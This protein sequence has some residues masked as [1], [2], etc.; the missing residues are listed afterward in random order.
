MTGLREALE[1]RQ[2]GIYFATVLAAAALG[3]AVP[4]TAALEAAINPALALMLFATFLQVPLADLGRALA[5]VRF[6]AALLAAN[7]LVAPLLVLALVQTLP[8][9]PMLR[10]GVL[11]VLL[12]PCIDYVVTFAHIGRADARL[13]LAATPVLL[14]AQMLLLPVYL[15][16]FLGEAAQ[17][18]VRAEPFLHAFVW[19]IAVPLALAAA[20]QVLAGRSE[21]AA[22]AVRGLGLL[23]VPATAVVLFVVVASVTPQLGLALEGAVRALPLYLAYAVAAP[24]LG[25]GVAR[26]AGLEAPAG[27]AVAF[28]AGTRNSLV[29]LPLAFAV[30][31]GAPL[32]PAIIVLQTLVELAASLAYMRLIP[33]LGARALTPPPD[34][35]GG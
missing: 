11:L 4:G 1:A 16:L 5:R 21:G 15:G 8:G 19:L 7:F 2:V 27:R 20:A 23:P 9:D 29:V 24:L 25:W 35:P 30:P 3:A 18:L 34:S 28:S 17:G 6:L 26:L 14:L 22:R 32:L 33:R 13:L 10:L 31:G 12:A